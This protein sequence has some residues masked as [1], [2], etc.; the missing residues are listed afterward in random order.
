MVVGTQARYGAVRP[1]TAAECGARPY[2]TGLGTGLWIIC[3][4]WATALLRGG[5]AER[6][7]DGFQ[8]RAAGRVQV[9]PVPAAAPQERV[10]KVAETHRYGGER[11]VFPLD[12]HAVEPGGEGVLAQE[13]GQVCR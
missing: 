8:V 11:E 5:Q 9:R 10:L 2:G 6:G 12:W 3:R 1:G 4:R 13:L 7:Q